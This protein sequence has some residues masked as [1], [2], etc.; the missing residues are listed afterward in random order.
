MLEYLPY[1]G[2]LGLA[3]QSGK[4]IRAGAAIDGGQ[5]FRRLKSFHRIDGI[6]GELSVDHQGRKASDT[7][8]PRLDEILNIAAA[9][10]DDG[11]S[12]LGFGAPIAI[13]NQ[14]CIV[15][16]VQLGL[17]SFNQADFCVC[18][19]NAINVQANVVALIQGGLNFTDG[20]GRGSAAPGEPMWVDTAVATLAPWLLRV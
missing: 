9:F 5:I 20:L 12:C 8:K 14:V 17:K 11:T 4:G 18:P 2:K 16:L 6:C 19:I 3:K 7:V 1:R 10:A 13:D 15:L